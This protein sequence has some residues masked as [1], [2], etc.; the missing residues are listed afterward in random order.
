M[1]ANCATVTF[2]CSVAQSG[3]QGEQQQPEVP[4]EQQ[5]EPSAEEQQPAPPAEEQQ[6]EPPAEEQQEQVGGNITCIIM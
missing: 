3:E 2:L 5:P 4:A 1:L 6:P